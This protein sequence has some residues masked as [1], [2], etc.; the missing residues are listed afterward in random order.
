MG[1][2]PSLSLLTPLSCHLHS[3]APVLWPRDSWLT[4]GQLWMLALAKGWSC[5]S[6]GL[7]GLEMLSAVAVLHS[8]GSS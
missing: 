4:A 5:L 3:L 1:Y 8:V 2:I 7:R 6:L